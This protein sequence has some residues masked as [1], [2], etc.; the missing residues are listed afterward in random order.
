MTDTGVA[1]P[2]AVTRLRELALSAAFAAAVRAAARLELADALGDR[3]ATAAELAAAVRA[4]PQAVG[5]LLRALACHEVFAELPDGRFVHT[6][7]SRL[8]R[9]DAPRSLRYTSLWATEDWTWML[10]PYLD[11]AVR[12]GGKVF[13][14]MFGQ[15]FFGYLHTEMPESAEIFDKAMT[16]ASK[17]SSQAIS[18]VL[19]LSGAGT[20]ADIGGGQGHMLISLLRAHP[21]LRGI[22]FD[23]PEVVANADPLL[24]DGGTLAGRVRL[25]PGDCRRQVPVQADVYLL[26]NVLEWEDE[27]TVATLRNIIAAARPGARV[28]VIEN[29]VDSS[30][31]S[32]FTTAMDLL[33]MLNVGGR[34]HTRDGLL[35][36]IRASG[37]TPTAVRPVNTYL[38]MI[39]STVG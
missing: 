35:E 26:K 39:E 38:H 5:R 6:D 18:K 21:G 4:D 2:A 10:W 30:P 15:D 7:A 37:L 11:D 27:L 24:R 20:V 36:L 28:V 3:P 8:L 16:Q 32:K 23:L 14:E 12:A 25:L 29:L 34:K 17:L 31:E 1:V 9:E 19:D 33:L 22:L 13:D